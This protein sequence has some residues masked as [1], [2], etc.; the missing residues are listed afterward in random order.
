MAAARSSFVEDLLRLGFK[1]SSPDALR[2]VVDWGEEGTENATEVRIEIGPAFPF[3][4]PRVRPIAFESEKSWHLDADGGMCLWDRSQASS[5]LPWGDASRLVARAS[6]WLQESEKGWPN[7]EPDLDLERY[8]QKEVGMF[9]YDD[10]LLATALGEA[11][12]TRTRHVNE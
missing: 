8:L 4:P 7:D 2:G 3:V 10:D 11:I 12:A 5:D 9:L 6:E 1:A